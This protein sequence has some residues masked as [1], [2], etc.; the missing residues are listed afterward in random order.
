M[1]ENKD[2]SHLPEK[3]H[4]L[5][6]LKKKGF[7]VPDFIYVPA[8]DFTSQ[9]F[10]ALRKFL[11]DHCQSFKVIARSAH[12]REEYFKGGTFDSLETYADVA[13][14]EYARKRIITLGK[15]SKRLAIL[16]QQT[17]NH[18]PEI[19]FEEMGLIVMPFID[20]TSVMAKMVGEEWEFGYSGDRIHKVQSDPFVTKTPH[21]RRLQ[22][23]SVEIQDYL[24][25]KS[26]I[27]YVISKDGEI[28]VVQAKDISSI[29]VLH[30]EASE[31]SIKLDGIRRI[32]KRRNYR[33]RPVY[34]MDRRAFYIDLITACE[35]IILNSEDSKGTI[36]DVLKVITSY[37]EELE[38]FSLRHER[39]AVLGLSVRVPEDLHQMANHYLDD[40]SEMQEQL[41]Q[42]LHNHLYQIDYFLAEADTLITKDKIRIAMCT[43]D[44][45]GIDSIRNPIWGV[46][47]K[48]E[49]HKHVV[50]EFKRLGFKTGDSL[51]IEID[52][53]EKPL[54]YRL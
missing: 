54:V 9:D 1:P 26:E 22:D 47:W 3:A 4:L 32:R 19:D 41:S 13:G 39:F 48:I 46:Y 11:A 44:A 45:Y 30:P 2:I 27:E 18:A 50:K 29:E 23:L 21:D 34:V 10:G 40:F 5:K 7:N 53:E 43:H 36:D 6:L 12:P 16:R 17:F 20:G 24:G 14:I 52:A 28:H 35:D 42:R 38:R 31:R 49:R 15:T 37:E 8:A 33:E 51:G 25:F